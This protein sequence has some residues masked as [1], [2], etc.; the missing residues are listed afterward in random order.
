MLLFTHLKS[1]NDGLYD[2][3]ENIRDALADTLVALRSHG[4]LR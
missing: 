4:G 3:V 1:D 2:A